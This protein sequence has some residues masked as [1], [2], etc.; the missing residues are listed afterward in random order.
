MSY[1]PKRDAPKKCVPF[2]FGI[3]V[4]F[5]TIFHLK[6]QESCAIIY[7]KGRFL[8][9][10]KAVK[11]LR[12]GLIG[13]GRIS[14]M[15]L[16]PA[17]NSEY[18]ELVC[19]CDIKKD[20]ANEVAQ[21]YGIKAYY[22]YEE[23]LKSEKLDAVHLCLPHYLHSKVAIAAFEHGV[24][25]LTEKPMDVDLESAEAAV[26]AAKEKGVLFGVIFQC[27][28]NNSA[29]LVKAAVESGR[30]GR[31]ISAG[32][33]LTWTR[34]DEYYAESD[35][36]G[37]WD[38]EGG[39]V[40]ID[41]AIHSIDL[42]NW[43][44]DSE[45]ASVSCSMANRGHS[46]VKVED[47]AEGLITYQNGVRYG[48]YCMNNYGCDE[49]IEIKLYCE[50][51][52]VTFGYDDAV[53]EY[54]DGSKEEAHQDANTVEY[55]GGKDYWGFQHGRQIEQFYKACLGLEAL[56][57]SGEVALKTHKLIMEIY[58]QGGMKPSK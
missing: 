24:H 22:D 31:I 40:V 30:L 58:R 50:K 14:V 45:V 41:Q 32:S 12:I 21:K 48:F 38:K 54:A 3:T 11:K 37:T 53:I 34:P 42:V 10:E 17:Q 23:M 47:S 27:R 51:G 2:C 20:R 8:N 5:S 15:H 39:G 35:W 46:I 52:K 4:R 16:I 57:I 33:T 18:A 7:K 9:M 19:C 26:R 44:V 1:N 55:E 29:R 43:I 28:Y 49:P 56:D 36:K 25:V 13:C 6:K